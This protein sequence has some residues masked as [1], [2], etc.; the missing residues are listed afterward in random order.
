MFSLH[1][2]SHTFL[3]AGGFQFLYVLPQVIQSLAERVEG[4]PCLG[5]V[6]FLCQR[7][8]RQRIALIQHDCPFY[9]QPHAADGVNREIQIIIVYHVASMPD[10]DC[11]PPGVVVLLVQDEGDRLFRFACRADDKSLVISQHLQPD[12]NVGRV[13]AEAGGGFESYVIDQRCR[14]YLG[15]K[16]LFAVVLCSKEGRLAETM[17][18]SLENGFCYNAQAHICKDVVFRQP[19]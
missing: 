7:I 6:R 19:K 5:K 11:S 16:L 17:A 8:Q 12:L 15:D 1:L 10:G 4:C 13:V 3:I 9:N 18:L 14:S 2:L